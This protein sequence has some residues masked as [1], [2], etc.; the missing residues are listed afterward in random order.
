MTYP[1]ARS[2]YSRNGLADV[3]G[4]TAQTLY[5]A[6]GYGLQIRVLGYLLTSSGTGNALLQGGPAVI[7]KIALPGGGMRPPHY[8]WGIVAGH[9]QPLTIAA[10]TDNVE[11]VG[12]VTYIV[13]TIQPGQSGYPNGLP[14]GLV[15]IPQ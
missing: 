11:I 4:Q 3:T 15:T 2:L 9:N 6:P 10:D 12:G 14:F 1:A 7:D 8:E 13:E 5:A